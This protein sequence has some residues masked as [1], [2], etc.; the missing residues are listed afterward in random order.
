MKTVLVNLCKTE[1]FKNHKSYKDSIDFLNENKIEFIDFTLG[2]TSIDQMVES[3]HKALDCEADLIWVISGGNKCIQTL[4]LIDWNKVVT[5]KK[6][7]Y[8]LSDFTHFSTMA[9]S[10]GVVCHYGQGLTNIKTYFPKSLDRQFIV[11]FLTNGQPVCNNAN[12]LT[13]NQVL[14]ITEQKI[15]GGHLTIFTLMQS[16]SQLNLSERFVF[17]EYHTST[18]GES[19]DDLGY[20]LDQLLYVLKDNS[21]Q[22]FILGHTVIRD[23]NGLQIAVEQI[24]QYLA[25]KIAKTGLPVFFLDHFTNTI[26]F[27]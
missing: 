14:K 13:N 9:V 16:Q 7:F 8:G 27:K 10:K 25:E 12:S 18:L 22:G 11:D 24:N 6:E 20:Y 19:L 4:N 3:F 17:I 21:P 15:V 5:S 26:T 2:V 1:D 23:I